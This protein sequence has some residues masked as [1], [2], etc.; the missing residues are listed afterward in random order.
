MGQRCKIKLVVVALIVRMWLTLKREK[1][2]ILDNSEKLDSSLRNKIAS[3]IS[4]EMNG[5]IK[6]GGRRLQK[7]QGVPER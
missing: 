2:N 7:Y 5:K 1:E 3:H 6:H 4:R